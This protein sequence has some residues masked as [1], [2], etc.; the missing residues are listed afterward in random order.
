MVERCALDSSGSVQGPV[1]DS[2]ECGNEPTG[3]IKRGE[4]LAQLSDY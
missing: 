1:V 2:C 3:S 4:F